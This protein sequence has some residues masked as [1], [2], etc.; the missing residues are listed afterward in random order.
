M[1]NDDT[2]KEY[3]SNLGY[4]KCHKTIGY[5]AS[6][7][8][9]DCQRLEKSDFAKKCSKDG[10][11]FK[12]CIRLAESGCKISHYFHSGEMQNIATNADF[13]VPFLSAHIT[14][15]SQSFYLQITRCLQPNL[16]DQ[17]QIILILQ[18]VF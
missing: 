4:D 17:R 15:D 12:C 9:K 3:E 6:P 11:F 8:Q 5:D 2:L 18:R 13:A 14:M 1:S 16:K 10:G 7:C